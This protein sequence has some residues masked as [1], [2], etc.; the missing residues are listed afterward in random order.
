MPSAIFWTFCI[1]FYFFINR[2][3]FKAFGAIDKYSEAFKMI[4]AW[5]ESHPNLCFCEVELGRKLH[6]DAI[7]A[8]AE[9]AKL[10]PCADQSRSE[11]FRNYHIPGCR[12][13][14]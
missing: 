12:V 2:N 7:S 13:T 10:S 8:Y 5:Q 9:Y 6:E 14:L 4:L 1:F 3:T 11:F